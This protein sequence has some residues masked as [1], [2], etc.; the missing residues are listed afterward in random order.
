[1]GGGSGGGVYG[2][3]S[4]GERCMGVAVPTITLFS[5]RINK[6]MGNYKPAEQLQLHQIRN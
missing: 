5:P 4:R 3:G 2:R 6:L 1:M